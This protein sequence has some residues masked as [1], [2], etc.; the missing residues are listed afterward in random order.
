MLAKRLLDQ[1]GIA[2]REIDV[3]SDPATR[4]WLRE[5]T[6]QHTVPQIFVGERSIGGYRE[7]YQLEREGKLDALLAE[8]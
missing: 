3:T 4:A 6:G 8:G 1:K 2:V 5:V 7:L